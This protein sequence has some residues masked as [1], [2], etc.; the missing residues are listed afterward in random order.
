MIAHHPI[1]V[2]KQSFRHRKSKNSPIK[3][4]F[5]IQ[6][7]KNIIGNFKLICIRLG[8]RKGFG[9]INRYNDNFVTKLF[10]Y[11]CKIR[12]FINAKR[13]PCCP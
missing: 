1:C 13:T 6:Q 12:K 5:W 7:K 4:I 9:A 3:G 10:L 11:F 2:H 8:K